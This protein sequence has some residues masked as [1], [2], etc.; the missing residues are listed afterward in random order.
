MTFVKFDKVV[1]NLNIYL[2]MLM[3]EVNIYP[4]RLKML[5]GNKCTPLTNQ[6]TPLKQSM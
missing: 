5:C 3:A 6:N 1:I 2:P 4:C